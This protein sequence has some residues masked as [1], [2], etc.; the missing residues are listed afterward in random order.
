MLGL[1][2]VSLDPPKSSKKLKKNDPWR[3]LGLLALLGVPEARF[4]A[5]FGLFWGCPG[6]PLG[7]I[8]ACFEDI[9]GMF[10]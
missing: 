3:L 1:I 9:L 6:G 7:V 4:W 8:L 2:L 10:F 5:P